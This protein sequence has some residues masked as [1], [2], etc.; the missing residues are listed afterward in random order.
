MVENTLATTL[1]DDR[2]CVE[3]AM[4]VQEVADFAREK[5]EHD[6]IFFGVR[7]CSPRYPLVTEDERAVQDPDLALLTRIFL[8]NYA[9]VA[10]EELRRKY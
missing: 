4:D 2:H 8:N 6:L 9:R 7:K 1:I 10:Q 5:R 3:I